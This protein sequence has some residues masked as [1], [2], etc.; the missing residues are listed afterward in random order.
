MLGLINQGP[1]PSGHAP[2]LSIVIPVYNEIHTIGQILLEVTRALREV[3]KQIVVVDDCSDDGTAGWLRRSLAD[4]EGV[5]R[6][7]SLDREGK[8]DLSAIGPKNEG[9]FS[10]TVLFHERNW[11]KAPLS[12]AD[13][14]ARRGMSSS[15]RTPTSNTIQATGRAC[16]R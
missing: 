2:V 6:G 11:A 9:G 10:F 16:C 5:W 15:S 4:A 14:H 1:T 13:W 3:H 8:L 12:E 7:M